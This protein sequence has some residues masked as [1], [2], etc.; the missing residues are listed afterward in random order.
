MTKQTG[1]S[2]VVSQ[3]VYDFVI[4]STFQDL[5]LSEWQHPIT[6]SLYALDLRLATLQLRQNEH[7]WFVLVPMHLKVS[8]PVLSIYFCYLLQQFSYHCN[9]S[10]HLVQCRLK[11]SSIPISLQPCTTHYYSARFK[12]FTWFILRHSFHLSVCPLKASGLHFYL[13]TGF[14]ILC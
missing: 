12:D 6:T 9:Q 2:L 14:W 11:Q 5:F 4:L 8:P 10:P 7:F 13:Q 1:I 3:I